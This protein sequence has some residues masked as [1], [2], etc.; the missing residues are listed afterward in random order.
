MIAVC[1]CGRSKDRRAKQCAECYH[2]RWTADEEALVRSLVAEGATFKAIGERLGRSEAA[3]THHARQI[4]A[5]HDEA[6][7]ASNRAAGRSAFWADK[8]KVREWKKKI[9]KALRTPQ[10]RAI[11]AEEL[12]Q[13]NLAGKMGVRHHSEETK[14]RIRAAHLGRVMAP[15]T[16]RKISE[17]RKAYWAAKRDGGQSAARA[18]MLADRARLK[19]FGE[20][21]EP[22]SAEVNLIWCGQCERRVSTQQA[23]VCGSPFCKAKEL[24]A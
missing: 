3:V 20:W 14:A 17:A 23:S 5:T 1:S 9:K 2:R 12:R 13:R 6:T 4:G 21:G 8:Q 11:F 16:R 10:S 19:A 15:E 24:A 7:I 18:A 22:T